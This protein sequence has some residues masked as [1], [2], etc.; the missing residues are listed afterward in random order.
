M[1]VMQTV[2]SQSV[3]TK[4]GEFSD[5]VKS[6]EPVIITQYR[7]PTMVVFSY[8]EAMEMMRLAAKMRFIQRLQKQAEYSKEPTKEELTEISRLIEEE[9]EV[10][11]QEKIKNAK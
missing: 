7:R 2:T 10:I 3:Q 6:R 11:Y 5:L 8:D 4:F 1:E 9:R